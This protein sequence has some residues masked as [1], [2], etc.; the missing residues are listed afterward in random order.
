MIKPERG[1]LKIG[2]T[3][4]PYVIERSSRRHKTI[5]LKFIED[6]RLRVAAPAAASRESIEGHLRGRS[7]TIVR[8]VNGLAGTDPTPNREYVNGETFEYLG[9][10]ARLRVVLRADGRPK[11]RMMHGR[12]EV[13]VQRQ[14]T[15]DRSSAVRAAL[16]EWYRQRC[17]VRLQ[18]RVHY[19][20]P[21]VGVMPSGVLLRSQERR[22]GS[23]SKDG[24]V[25]F[26]WRIIMAPA[27]LIDYVVV[28]EL[29]HLREVHHDDRFWRFVGSVLPDYQLRRERLRRSGPRFVL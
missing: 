20:A 19:Y 10:Q 23:C 26:N 6:G 18:E 1:T 13:A 16:R 2:A 17:I 28:H 3:R 5:E 25:R 21:L 24:I 9:R 7:A 29:C 14:P 12:F 27:A 8:R 15:S 22:W 11:A 4:V